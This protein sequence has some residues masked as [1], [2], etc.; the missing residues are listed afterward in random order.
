MN[1]YQS[2]CSKSPALPAFSSSHQVLA[3]TYPTGSV[4]QQRSGGHQNA[5]LAKTHPRLPHALHAGCRGTPFRPNLYSPGSSAA[6]RSEYQV[7]SSCR[8]QKPRAPAP[9][10]EP[11]GDPCR[12]SCWRSRTLALSINSSGYFFMADYDFWGRR[13]SLT[14]VILPLYIWKVF[15]LFSLM[16]ATDPGSIISMRG[17]FGSGSIYGCAGFLSRRRRRKPLRSALG[18]DAFLVT[19]NSWFSPKTDRAI[20]VAVFRARHRGNTVFPY[21]H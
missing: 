7:S 12:D 6:A 20:C 10:R 14:R 15:V 4:P 1:M 16:T 17:V 18:T 9:G 5:A 11:S 21:E 8:T 3:G 2:Q 13:L 19:E